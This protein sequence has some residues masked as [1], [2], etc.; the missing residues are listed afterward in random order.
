MAAFPLD[1]DSCYVCSFLADIHSRRVPIDSLSDM[2]RICGLLEPWSGTAELKRKEQG[3][4]R[5]QSPEK[6]PAFVF[7]GKDFPKMPD[8]TSN[9]LAF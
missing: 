3:I 5:M 8:F 1:F 9:L 4:F 6:C 7:V 2:G